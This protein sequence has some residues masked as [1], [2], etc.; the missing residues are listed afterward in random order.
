MRVLSVL[1]FIVGLSMML[2]VVACMSSTVLA[3]PS[4]ALLPPSSEY[5]QDT[6]SDGFFDYLIIEVTVEVYEAGSFMVEVELNDSSGINICG[7]GSG[8]TLGVGIHVVPLPMEGIK[9]WDHGVDGPY[10][11]HASLHSYP[12]AFVDEYQDVTD[13]YTYDQFEHLPAMF[14]IVSG[15]SGLDT[16]GNGRN[17]FLVTSFSVD[18]FEANDYQ[19]ACSLMK[20]VD[21]FWVY[22]EEVEQ[23]RYLDVGK[24]ALS[25][26]IRGSLINA[27][28]LSGTY[29]ILLHLSDD[30]G[31]VRILDDIW[32]VT[33]SFSYTEFEAGSFTSNWSLSQPSIDGVFGPDEWQDSTIIDLG[34]PDKENPLDAMMFV[35]NGPTH[36]YICLD[37]VGDNSADAGDSAS[38][39]FDTS[40]DN[41]AADGMEDQ[42]MVCQAPDQ[43]IHNIYSVAASDWI[44]D[45]R[46]FDP[47]LPDH[48]GIAGAS[49]FGTSTSSASNHRIYEFAIPLALIG[50]EPGDVV[51]F[52]ANSN[53]SLGI[54]DATMN[55]GSS[56][57]YFMGANASLTDY[58]DLTIGWPPIVTS[59]TISGTVGEGGWYVSPV[60]VTL[61][62]SGGYL[63]IARTEYLLDLGSWNTYVSTVEFASE[64][65][66]NLSYRSYDLK[67]N[68]E[69]LSC[70]EFCVDVTAPST[71]SSM[72][73]RNVTLN[74]TDSVSGHNR[75]YYRIDG[76]PW[77]NYTG[78]IEI[79]GDV[80]HTVEYYSVDNAG[81]TE[82]TKTLIVEKED[83]G[84]AGGLG[85]TF[86][87]VLLILALLIIL[88]VPK[89]F[90]MRRRAKESDAKAAIKDLGSPM[91]QYVDD[92]TTKK[93]SPP[94]KEDL[95]KKQ[96]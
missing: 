56:W 94:E 7:Y 71:V 33:D 87:F 19:I 9:I 35:K 17:E 10:M 40:N 13:P 3:Q 80:D 60:N 74:A 1:A 25:I 37:A 96:Q 82:E 53:S 2:P 36:I 11:I 95:P 85:F 14:D 29:Y 23:N 18:V 58:G 76:G 4:A 73:D 89:L 47:T 88:A 77:E 84:G 32:Y 54:F 57:P 45:C 81:N 48:G 46:P 38:V 43:S 24:Q 55:N 70:L 51:G 69:E 64:G 72:S 90:G 20:L 5:V 39:A 79:P 34:S 8:S 31:G 68:S 78:P 42:F 15:A 61:S 67:G 49:G 52:A 65:S 12:W 83:E 6:D 75:T 26:A 59:A 63:G 91:A 66:H 92:T 16:D 62:A 30:V 44:V 41:S 21:S 86:W 50:L 28:E 93:E 22:I 27:A